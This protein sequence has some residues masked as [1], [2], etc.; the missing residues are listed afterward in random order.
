MV[1]YI[2]ICEDISFFEQKQLLIC[3]ERYLSLQ[4]LNE[5]RK[6]IPKNFVC[7]LCL[8]GYESQ[9]VPKTTGKVV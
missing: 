2:V 3:D 8:D 6:N 7:Q 4:G 1:V 5:L 9:A